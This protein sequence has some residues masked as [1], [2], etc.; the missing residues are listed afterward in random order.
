MDAMACCT[1]NT[2][3]FSRHVDS[4]EPA[5]SLLA[6]VDAWLEDYAS[7]AGAVLDRKPKLRAHLYNSVEQLRSQLVH[8]MEPPADVAV[9]AKPAPVRPATAFPAAKFP[10]A[11]AK[12]SFEEIELRG[13]KSEG[14][15]GLLAFG[16][17]C[18][19]LWRDDAA[20]IV[21]KKG[22]RPSRSVLRKPGST[23]PAGTADKSGSPPAV[24]SG[25]CLRFASGR[26]A[27]FTPMPRLTRSTSPN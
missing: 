5:E 21:H 27:S 11:A 20:A 10:A 25:Y 17:H 22:A 14:F 4:Q 26:T 3:C 24:R 2:R 6:E 1:G 16:D 18:D 7:V 13:F 15:D 9:R 8:S 19:V 12:L 23:T